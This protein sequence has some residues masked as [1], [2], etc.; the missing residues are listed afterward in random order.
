MRTMIIG[1]LF[2]AAIACFVASISMSRYTKKLTDIEKEQLA[3]RPMS[4]WYI[5]AI[6]I[7]IGLI[8]GKF[9]QELT[10]LGYIIFI[11]TVG[12]RWKKGIDKS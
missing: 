9:N 12:L 5:V 6:F 8:L 2:V 3:R 11:I 4:W 7:A 10:L 1:G